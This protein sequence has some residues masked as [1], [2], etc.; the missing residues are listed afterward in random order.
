MAEGKYIV[1]DQLVIGILYRNAD[2]RRI[3]DRGGIYVLVYQRLGYD[4]CQLLLDQMVNTDL[5]VPVNG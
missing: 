5:Q 2:L 3:R 1:V 4:T